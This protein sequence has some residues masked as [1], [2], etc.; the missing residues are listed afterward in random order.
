MQLVLSKVPHKGPS[1]PKLDRLV[2]WKEEENKKQ[3]NLKIHRSADNHASNRFTHGKS[4]SPNQEIRRNRPSKGSQSPTE[5]QRRSP[6]PEAAEKWRGRQ[7]QHCTR[8]GQEPTR[9]QNLTISTRTIRLNPSLENLGIRKKKDTY[10]L[11]LSRQAPDLNTDWHYARQTNAL[12]PIHSIQAARDYCHWFDCQIVDQGASKRYRWVSRYILLSI[13]A[14]RH[15][16]VAVT[17]PESYDWIPQARWSAVVYG[18]AVSAVP[19]LNF[20]SWYVPRRPGVWLPVVC[21]WWL[22]CL[23]MQ[24]SGSAPD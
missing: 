21:H 3:K 2:L 23:E 12:A 18:S 19:A 15:T 7:D 20:F 4:T 22:K 10:Q 24:S 17:S 8:I 13:F 9:D 14:T 6:N 11:K 16:R 5:Q 1:G